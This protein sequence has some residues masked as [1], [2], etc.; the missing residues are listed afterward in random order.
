MQKTDVKGGRTKR[1][2]R[3]LSLAAVAVVAIAAVMVLSTGLS[4]AAAVQS[5]VTSA[6]GAYA[7]GS[8]ISTPI[9]K[10][11]SKAKHFTVGDG[12]NRAA[13]DPVSHDMYF[14]ESG[15]GQVQVF[16]AKN[17]LVGTVSLGS[18]T[19]PGAAAF[20][21]VNNDVYVTGEESDAVYVISGT[22]L[23]DTITSSDFSEP[24]GIAY[25]PGDH[26]IGV[27]NFGGNDVVWINGEAIIQTSPAGTEPFG[28]TY[29]PY[30]ANVLVTNLGSDNV[31]CYS[32]L[33]LDVDGNVAV[34]DSPTGIA[35]DPAVSLDYVANI[36]SNNV[37]VISGDCGS[38]FTIT[39]FDGPDGV[40]FSQST[41][42]MYIT[43]TANGDVN[44]VYYSSIVHTYTTSSSADPV[45]ATYDAYNN[46]VYVGSFGGSEGTTVY[47]L[48]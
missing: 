29:D 20:S 11:K 25:D 45:D 16:S 15:A 46:D 8:I 17:K 13:Y 24:Y 44:T 23:V 47:V 12:P 48:A 33:Y 39:G 38:D 40:G 21:P 43:N 19:F 5:R 3:G 36:D 31:T 37:S 14:P 22:T 1:M 6:T 2:N 10:A 30:W 27:A 28:I 32:A 41:L 4:S 9:E 42:D 26:A 18:D 34:G 35:F 7:K